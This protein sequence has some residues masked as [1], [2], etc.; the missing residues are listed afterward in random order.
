MKW[1]CAGINRIPIHMTATNAERYRCVVWW[2]RCCQ[3]Y[4]YWYHY[5]TK[6]R[7]AL[8]KIPNKA[9]YDLPSI[10]M[11]EALLEKSAYIKMCRNTQSLNVKC[12]L[13]FIHSC[14]L[15]SFSRKWQSAETFESHE[16]QGTIVCGV[17]FPRTVQNIDHPL[18]SPSK[19]SQWHPLIIA[20]TK[21]T[22][23]DFQNTLLGISPALIGN[24]YTRYLKRKKYWKRGKQPW[25]PFSVIPFS[26]S[27][28]PLHAP[29]LLLHQY[30]LLTISLCLITSC[31][32]LGKVC[33]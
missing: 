25:D 28:L 4:C 3:Q 5:F 1:S 18:T 23:R 20:T 26:L 33:R 21:T 14:L 7:A 31:K 15:T 2:L 10:Y 19:F 16:R 12:G 29:L 22:C 11:V 6:W 27:P 13:D 9:E 30:K 32:V 24:H 17:E 8:G